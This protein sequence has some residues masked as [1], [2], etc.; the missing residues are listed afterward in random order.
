MSLAVSLV[1]AVTATHGRRDLSRP[2]RHGTRPGP[3]ARPSSVVAQMP[4]RREPAAA[5][6]MTGTSAVGSSRGRSVGTQPASGA[7]SGS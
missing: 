3:W 2:A 4:R 1:D 6:T 5:F 7:K